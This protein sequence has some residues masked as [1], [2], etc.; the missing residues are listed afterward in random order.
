MPRY[1][2]DVKAFISLD[3]IADNERDA[4]EVADAFVENCL[5]ADHETVRGYN[6]GLD[7]PIGVVVPA[8]IEPAVDGESDVDL[9]Y[10]EES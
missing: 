5:T 9:S 1:T 10:E 2:V 8:I 3:V 6:D 4:Q 7:N